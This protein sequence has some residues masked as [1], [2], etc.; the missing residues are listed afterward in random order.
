MDHQLFADIYDAHARAVYAHAVRMTADRAGAEDVVSLTFLQAWRLRDTLESVTS[1][2][3]W[4]LG[5]A[6]NV[7]RN[8][9]RTARRH[10]DAMTR[11]PPPE[12]VPDPADAVVSRLADA[13]QAAAA[14]AVLDRLRRADR[15]ALLLHVWSGLS[16]EEVARACGVPVGTVRSR[17][18]RA[19]ARLRR[20]TDARLAQPP[21]P[22]RLPV[23]P[24]AR[25][26]NL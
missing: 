20:L 21:A 18:S 25:E 15:E 11:L 12:A 4:L 14:L 8:T 22:G 16:H 17:L 3:A 5:I 7:M 6:T 10:R 26:G 24:A 2:R 19:R 13:A 1:H 23:S 9:R